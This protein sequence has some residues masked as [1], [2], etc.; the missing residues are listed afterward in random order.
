VELT[1]FMPLHPRAAALLS[2]A[3]NDVCR[4]IATKNYGPQG[5][6]VVALIDRVTALTG[7]EL[8]NL[9]AAA[10][11]ASTVYIRITAVRA[12][13]DAAR[14]AGRAAAW[15][16]AGHAAWIA[17]RDAP[18]WDTAGR[19]AWCPEWGAAGAAAEEAAGAIVCGDLVG[20]RFTHE[21][22]DLLAGPWLGDR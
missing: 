8:T 4:H 18:A 5:R 3:A 13:R 19:A 14:A 12:S 21:Q 7:Q 22:Y 16:A 17:V 15:D 20:E 11:A 10:S 1:G 2:P 9:A 6:G